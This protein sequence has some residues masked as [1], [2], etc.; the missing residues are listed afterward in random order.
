MRPKTALLHIG[1]PKTG[2]TSIQEF[3]TRAEM[4]GSLAPIRYPLWKGDRNHLRLTPLYRPYEELP[5]WWRHEF[6]AN[7]KRFQRM[8][9][10][11]RRYFFDELRSASGAIISAE[12][13]G[14]FTPAYADQ[15]R[16]DLES[17]GFKAF[18]I[19]LYVRDP[20]DYFLSRTQQRLK[21]ASEPE[22]VENP[23]SF[24]YQF[25]QAAETWE[26]IFPGS[27]IVRR[28]PNSPDHDVVDDFADVV[29]QCMGVTLP[30]FTVRMNTTLSAEA[31]QII[32]DYRQAFWPDN[33]G[34]LT[35]DA[36]WL[37]KFLK[38]S[39]LDVPQTKPVL[40]PEVAELIRVN[41]SADAANILARYGVDLG[42]Q[43]MHPT[44]APPPQTSY[45]VEEILT[46][47]DPE[48]VHQLLL[49]LART[50]LGRRPAQRPLPLRLAAGTYHSI[51]LARRPP[52]LDGWLRSFVKDRLP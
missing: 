49:R 7:D 9:R 27:L 11:F 23:A 31:M 24:R 40:K 4:D 39:A 44:I 41:H 17:L 25:L 37:V 47:V 42:L 18:H 19:V 52:R 51:P 12:G 28:F 6:P 34:N 14:G 32:Q 33:G 26:Q 36:S 45:H 20:A 48:I 30:R 46:S 29:K 35:P 10:Q 50:E 16:R 5:P 43:N 21:T 13:L 2:S 38:Q 22:F 3:L 1:T 8:R 15:L